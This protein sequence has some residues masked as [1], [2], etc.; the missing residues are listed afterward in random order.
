MQSVVESN[1]LEEMM[2]LVSGLLHSKSRFI[3]QP[4][5]C[6]FTLP[7]EQL[8]RLSLGRC[9]C[10]CGRRRWPVGTLLQSGSR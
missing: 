9:V 8:V 7:G 6:R 1:D 2:S 10:V 3:A 5:L 4:T